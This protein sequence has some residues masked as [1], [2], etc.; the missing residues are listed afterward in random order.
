MN[1]PMFL[2]VDRQFVLDYKQN[3]Y[4]LPMIVGERARINQ[5]IVDSK[6][7]HNMFH[8]SW[9]RAMFDR[10]YSDL[11]G[12][13]ILDVAGAYCGYRPLIEQ[14][15]YELLDPHAYFQTDGVRMIEG[16]FENHE[17]DT[18]YDYVLCCDLFLWHGASNFVA[19]LD[20]YLPVCKELRFSL[21]FRYRNTDTYCGW[22]LDELNEALREYGVDQH[23]NESVVDMYYKPDGCL[24][25]SRNVYLV[26]LRGDLWKE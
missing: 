15:E 18:T 4:L 2:R 16:T 25:N 3:D 5:K 7:Y 22:K 6:E 12:Q 1:N 13:K 24:P 14:N 19:F 10:M 8:H 21:T 23:R 9:K 20:K 11:K 26:G 17:L